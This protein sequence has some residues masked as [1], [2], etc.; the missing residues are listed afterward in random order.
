[1]LS[2]IFTGLL[3]FVSINTTA[4]QVHAGF[5]QVTN[6]LIY[7]PDGYNTDTTRRWPLMVFLHGSGESG[8]D[9]DKVKVNGPPKLVAD[10]KKFPFIII[11]PQASSPQ[12]GFPPLQ[13]H[14]LLADVKEHNRVDPDRVYLTG[15]SMGGYGAWKIAQEY[16]EDFAAVIPVCGGGDTSLNWKLRYMPV[17]NFHG[18]KDMNVPISQSDDMVSS[19]RKYNPTIRY[20]IYP[21]VG[22]NS[23]EKAYD[24][25]S[26]YTWML[27]QTR[28]RF[29][30][31]NPDPAS[32]KLYEGKFLDQRND[33][34]VFQSDGKQLIVWPAGAPDDKLPLKSSG[35][36]RFYINDRMLTEIVFP[37][38]KSKAPYFTL[39]DRN[40][41]KVCRRV[42]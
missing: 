21:E 14:A 22:H 4:Q 7:Y 36:G 2:R 24:T 23:W 15:L 1:M 39:Y 32:L 19:L 26:L 28:F 41:R 9:V 27:S 25:D 20:T 40:D 31:T 35:P 8:S 30:E 34:L 10:G 38:G 5:T 12:V 16:P 17:W 11:S 6:Y 37:S 29:H 3:L 18:G 13:V 42:K 33:T